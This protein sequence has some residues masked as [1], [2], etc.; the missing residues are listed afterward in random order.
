MSTYTYYPK[1]PSEE[2]TFYSGNVTVN[3]NGDFGTVSIHSYSDAN[4]FAGCENIFSY[5]KNYNVEELNSGAVS[6]SSSNNFLFNGIYLK[7]KIMNNSKIL[8]RV[9]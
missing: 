8:Y 2:Y 4:G 7:G 6:V 1:T 5:M 9:G 3:S